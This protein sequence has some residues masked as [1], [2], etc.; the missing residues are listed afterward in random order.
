MDMLTKTKIKTSK[1]VENN[2]IFLNQ[3]LEKQNS[4]WHGFLMSVIQGVGE[5]IGATL[6][7]GV[8]LIILSKFITS[9]EQVPLI[10][11]LVKST[12]IEKTINPKPL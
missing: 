9:V 3:N 12:Q 5:V 10:G 7:A 11:K 6:V 8:V 4:F 1:S 2:L